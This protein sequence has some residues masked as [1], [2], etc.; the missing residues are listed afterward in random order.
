MKKIRVGQVMTG[1]ITVASTSH[2]FSQVMEFFDKFNMRHLPVTE[3]DKVVGILSM[4][5]VMKG[6][7]HELLNGA[8]IDMRQMDE[9][10][11][12]AD[13]MTPTPVTIH[14]EAEIEEA[15]TMLHKGHFHALPVAEEGV[16]KGIITDYDMLNAY[17][18]EKVPSVHYSVGSP[19]FG[20]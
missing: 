14:P 8:Q 5:D 16:I 9:K 15:L 18:H 4:R 17:F 1:Q 3:G 6:L 10:L 12:I 2:K 11:K 19:G 7:Y 13:L 20:I